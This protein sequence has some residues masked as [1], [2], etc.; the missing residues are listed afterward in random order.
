MFGRHAAPTLGARLFQSVLYAGRLFSYLRRPAGRRP[1]ACRACTGCPARGAR[2]RAGDPVDHLP[3]LRPRVQ[4]VGRHRQLHFLADA[5]VDREV[6]LHAPRVAHE[7]AVGRRRWPPRAARPGT[8]SAVRLQVGR[9]AERRHAARQEAVEGP[10]VAGLGRVDAARVSCPTSRR[11]C[12]R[13]VS[14]AACRTRAW[15]SVRGRAQL[16]MSMRVN[17]KPLLMLCLPFSQLRL[18]SSVNCAATPALWRAVGGRARQTLTR[19][20]RAGNPKFQPL[21]PAALAADAGAVELRRVDALA[22]VGA[23]A[24]RVLAAHARPR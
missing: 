2:A 18:S 17:E 10:R 9:A 22:E 15:P 5:D 8:C 3:G 13:P 14:A 16:R 4:A 23:Q 24:R 12:C 11:A 19:A 21:P 1:S 20:H 6:R 7:E